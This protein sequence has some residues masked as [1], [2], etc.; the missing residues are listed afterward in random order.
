MSRGGFP[1]YSCIGVCSRYL[2]MADPEC[3]C[4][5]E[6]C[7]TWRVTAYRGWQYYGGLFSSRSRYVDQNCQR[8]SVEC[9]RWRRQFQRKR[10]LRPIDHVHVDELCECGSFLRK[11]APNCACLD[12][13]TPVMT[14]PDVLDGP[15][16]RCRYEHRVGRNGQ[17]L[18]CLAQAQGQGGSV[19]RSCGTSQVG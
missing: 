6:E 2:G 19:G 13:Q 11:N 17:Y 9:I 8:D 7:K 16:S 10:P 12:D 1:D 3:R 4:N 5:N 15:C 18:A 14:V